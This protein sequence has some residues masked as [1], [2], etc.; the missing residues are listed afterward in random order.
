[1]FRSL[2]A[3]I[4]AVML[5]LTSSAALAQ[6][7]DDDLGESVASPVNITVSSLTGVLG[8]GSVPVVDAGELD[9]ADAPRPQ[10]ELRLRLLIENIADTSIQPLRTIVEIHP[11]VTSRSQL[12][13]ALAGNLESLPVRV[14]DETL[15]AGEAL[16]AGDIAGARHHFEQDAMPWGAGGVFPLRIAV[17]RGTEVLAEAFTAVVWLS[18][19][20][21]NPLRSVFVWPF[22]APPNRAP[23]GIYD[24]GSDDA[25]RLGGQLERSIRLLEQLGGPGVVLAPAPHV[26]EELRDRAGGFIERERLDDGTQQLRRVSSNTPAARGAGDLLEAVRGLIDAAPFAPVTS[27]YARADLSA[28]VAADE[29]G[30][31]LALASEAASGSA[32][33]LRILLDTEPDSAT[34]VL[35]PGTTAFALDLIPSGRVLVPASAVHPDDVALTGAA[36]D[37]GAI[38]PIR[39]LRTP[40]GR[41]LTAVVADPYLS[42]QLSRPDTRHGSVLAAQRIV[43]SSAMAYFEAPDV[44]DRAL[45]ILPDNGWDPG[46]AVAR[47]V[48]S[49]LQDALWLTFDS[50]STMIATARRSAY[51]L[52]LRDTGTRGIPSAFHDDLATAIRALEAAEIA[53]PDEETLIGGLTPGE[54]DDALTH[55]TSQWLRGTRQPFATELVADVTAAVDELF[56][57]IEIGD[58]RVTLT[59]DSGTIPVT[60]DRP[61]G[62]PIQIRVEVASQGRLVWSE[63]R[64]SEPVILAPESRHTVSFATTALSTGTFP[65]TVRVT[66]PSG[67]WEFARETLSVRSTAI[68]RPALVATTATIVLLLG[69]GALRQP[70]SGRKRLRVVARRNSDEIG[71]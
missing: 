39:P 71:V 62:G 53:A 37:T 26:V 32:R 29:D 41:S 11:A 61:V 45:L 56:G 40:A 48:V 52:M 34:Y 44:S 12:H 28:L 43:A 65:V 42:E 15:R 46:P 55:A 5:V 36:G 63:G 30:R 20:P 64:F 35:D 17:V 57:T 66:D 3:P 60:L 27:T 21:S 54:L 69:V 68:S 18:Q 59:S 19:Q 38:Q 50:P 24:N 47:G 14:S 13:A 25:I 33:R 58:S 2:A 8:P 10:L 1:M 7:G 49:A 67:H 6:T 70:A 22:D 23:G 51:P 16:A 9:A 4:V 31:L